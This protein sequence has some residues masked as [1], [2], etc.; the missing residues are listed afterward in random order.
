[1]KPEKMGYDDILKEIHNLSV[2]E[3]L[4]LMEELIHSLWQDLSVHRPAISPAERVRGMLK[5]DGQ[6]KPDDDQIADAY[7]QNLIDKYT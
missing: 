5:L 7:T 4:R 1:M 3:R 2:E 6:P